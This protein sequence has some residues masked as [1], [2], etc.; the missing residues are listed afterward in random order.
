[1]RPTQSHARRIKKTT[2]SKK[3]RGFTVLLSC[4]RRFRA[5]GIRMRM[6]VKGSSHIMAKSGIGKPSWNA[7]LLTN[8]RI[9]NGRARTE[10][11]IAAIRRFR[12]GARRRARKTVT[13]AIASV[14]NATIGSRRTRTSS[15][16]ERRNGQLQRV[17]RWRLGRLDV[18]I[19]EDGISVRIH[20][21]EEGRPLL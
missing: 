13:R 8:S 2:P 9:I 7:R 14:A 19:N 5:I 12:A 20:C 6:N 1:M 4:V 17:V 15:I 18:L 16:C 11:T 3:L 21:H 10:L